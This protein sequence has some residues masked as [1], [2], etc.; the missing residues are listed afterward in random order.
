VHIYDHNRRGVV[1][2]RSPLFLYLFVSIKYSGKQLR[3]SSRNVDY[4]YSFWAKYAKI[5]STYWNKVLI[6]I[7]RSGRMCVCFSAVRQ[8]AGPCNALIFY[9]CECRHSNRGK[10]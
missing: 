10:M 4:A 7:L 2:G 1:I 5:K 6:K 3:L 9:Y 8:V